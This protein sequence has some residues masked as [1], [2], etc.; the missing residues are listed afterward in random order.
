MS[1]L[2]I[3]GLFVFPRDLVPPVLPRPIGYFPPAP[4]GCCHTRV[5]ARAAATA[6]LLNIKSC[7]GCDPTPRPFS[8]LLPSR[9][10]DLVWGRG[11]GSEPKPAATPSSHARLDGRILAIPSREGRIGQ[12]TTP[13]RAGP[14]SLMTCH[15]ADGPLGARQ[16]RPSSRLAAVPSAI[17]MASADGWD[18]RNLIRSWDSGTCH[19]DLD[20]QR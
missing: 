6:P 14:S 8:D 13:P 4:R 3:E 2:V 1:R 19:G 16:S 12:Y 11:I 5:F 7:R 9:T 15:A 17:V 10:R 18:A 20:R